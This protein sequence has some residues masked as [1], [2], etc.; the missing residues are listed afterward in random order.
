MPTLEPR[1]FWL[2]SVLPLPFLELAHF[3]GSTIGMMLLLLA[4][5]LQRRLNGAYWASLT[6]LALGLTASLFKGL[7]VEEAFLM[8]V[9]LVALWF[10]RRF[11]IA[12]VR[13]WT[14]ASPPPGWP[15]LPWWP[16]AHFGWA[17]SP[18]SMWLT[19]A[20]C[21]GSS[22]LTLTRPVFCVPRPVQRRYCSVFP[23]PGCCDRPST[24]RPRPA[25]R[26]GSR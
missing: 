13:C 6:L 11:F 23:L 24:D 2:R 10:S 25:M 16:S 15:P 26:N 12:A 19:A 14:S 9:L 7:D 17:F 3:V 5:G 21:G 20:I 18:T 4:R 8:A 1:L 22:L